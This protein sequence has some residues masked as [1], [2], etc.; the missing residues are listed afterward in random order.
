MCTENVSWSRFSDFFAPA[1]FGE[2]LQSHQERWHE[3]ADVRLEG[4]FRAD[5]WNWTHGQINY[6]T[7]RKL[8]GKVHAKKRIIIHSPSCWWKV[9]WRLVVHKTFQSILLNWNRWRLVLKHLKNGRQNIKRLHTAWW[10]I[11]VSKSPKM[12]ETWRNLSYSESFD[13]DWRK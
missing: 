5:A 8:K 4:Q 3:T 6:T 2:K 12:M 9:G 1:A 13:L 10:V 7:Q 11:Q